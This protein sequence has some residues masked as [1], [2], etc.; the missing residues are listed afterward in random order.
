MFPSRFTNLA[1]ARLRFGDRVDR[2]GRYF[3]QV[4]DLA[5]RVVLA[6]ESLPPGE[7]WRMFEEATRRG[8]GQVLD[9]PPSFRDFFGEAEHVPMWVDWPTLDRGGEVLVRAGA[10]GGIVLGLKSIVLGYTSP[11]GN[12]PL[13]FSGRLTSE[14]TRRLH[15]TARFVEATI[16]HGGLRAGAD[17]YR[18]ALKVRLIHAQVRR[19]ILRSDAWNAR[20]WG[21]PI[22]QHDMV[23]T[24][25]LFSTIV[26]TGLEQLGL[27]VSRSDAEAYIQLWRYSGYLMGVDPE[28]IP[29]SRAEAESLVDLI[30][31]TQG[32]PDDDSRA[33]TRALLE[34][35]LLVAKTRRDRRNAERMVRFSV[36]MCRELLGAEVADQLAVPKS[37]WTLALP[38]LRRLVSGVDKIRESVPYAET[39]AVRAGLRYWERVVAL[40]LNE[41]T[42]E[43]GLPSVIRV[44]ASARGA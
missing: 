22:N 44:P 5:D 32:A 15:E 10:L 17:G 39:H 16:R 43:F 7:G 2:L 11:A 26:L 40:G 33:L 34:A 30:A 35:P 3:G 18:I 9:A 28:L 29:T 21:A 27:R 36:G 42:M 23:G 13:M 6:I 4:D 31:A 12:K 20:A 19:M 24:L 25:L 1:A 37:S 8:V 38:L 41:A 14:V